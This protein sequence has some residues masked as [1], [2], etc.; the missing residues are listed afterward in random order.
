[1]PTTSPPGKRSRTWRWLR[2]LVLYPLVVLV[3]AVAALVI[4][5]QSTTFRAGDPMAEPLVL[6][7][8]TA[9]VGHDLKPLADAVVVVQDGTV[10]QVGPAAAVTVPDGAVLESLP[11]HT[12]LP[13]LIDSHVHLT[14]PGGEGI[15]AIAGSVV[16]YLR[17]AGPRREA[18]LKHGVTSVRGMG[19]DPEWI[20]TLRRDVEQGELAGPRVFASGPVFT[21]PGGHPVA[22][23][24]LGEQD[25]SV[26]LP[27]TPEE[28]RSMVRDLAGGDDPV[29]MVKVVH[30]RGDPDHRVLDPIPVP[31]LDAIVAEAHGHGTPVA[32]HW[33]TQADLEELLAAG[34]DALD[35][36]EPRGVEDGWD[37]ELMVRVVADDL[38]LAPT[39]VVVEPLLAPE[40]L[41]VL[42]DRLAEYAGAG[43]RVVAGSDAPMNGVEFGEGLV[44]ELELL[45][46]AGL[47]PQEAL[48]AATS[49]AAEVMG[50]EEAGVLEP[51]RPA[52]LLIVRGDP[53]ADIAAIRQVALVVREGT[54]VVDNLS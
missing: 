15:G 51:G 27:S 44:R 12:V 40:R 6:T 50:T 31:V 47:S 3:L 34:V 52:D 4:W 30:D 20:R 54:P 17:Y 8:V 22:T 13:G 26:R 14:A 9:L 46:G 43:G 10:T 24:G 45:V 42:Q 25:A 33:G 28:A 11:G 38:T 37:E 7:D 53:M 18:Y 19:D 48:R 41:R 23:L 32:A 36:L 35:H 39:L 5:V 16:E 2:R 49:T 21:T 1:M 29:D